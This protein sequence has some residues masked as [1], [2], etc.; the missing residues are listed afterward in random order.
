M[1]HCIFFGINPHVSKYHAFRYHHTT[2]S[3]PAVH[4]D[5]YTGGVGDLAAHN[6]M[7]GSDGESSSVSSIR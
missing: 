7:V 6:I 4:H 5:G 3:T 1:C 2:M